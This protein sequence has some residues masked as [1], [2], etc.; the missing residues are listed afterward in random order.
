MF[1]FPGLPPPGL[2]VRPGGDAPRRRAGFSHSETRG[3]EGVCPSPRII[4]ACRVLRRLPVPRHPPPALTIF[5]LSQTVWFTT[6]VAPLG[7]ALGVILHEMRS[8]RRKS[9]LVTLCSSQGTARASPGDRTPRGR[10]PA[11]SQVRPKGPEAWRLGLTGRPVAIIKCSLEEVVLPRKEVIQ[12]HLPVRLPCY[13]FTP[14]TSHTFGTS[15]PCGLGR[16]LR[17]QATRVV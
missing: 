3:S 13:D 12:P 16:R 5:L 15:P 4:A 7:G 17:V 14:L 8:S 6:H 9:S 11:S 2:C 10:M 1:Q